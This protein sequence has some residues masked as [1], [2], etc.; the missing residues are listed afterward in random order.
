MPVAIRYVYFL[1]AANRHLLS[2]ISWDVLA[3]FQTRL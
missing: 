3:V 2:A 1:F